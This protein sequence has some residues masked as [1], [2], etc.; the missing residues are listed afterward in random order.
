MAGDMFIDPE[1]DPRL[2]PPARADERATLLG[3]LRFQRA[4]LELKCDGLEAVDQ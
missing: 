2:D 4:T 1:R 3:F